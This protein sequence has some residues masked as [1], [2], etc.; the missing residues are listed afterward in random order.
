MVSAHSSGA[1]PSGALKQH[2][3][4]DP[5]DETK[6]ETLFIRWWAES[7]HVPPNPHARMTHLSWGRWLLDK[8]KAEL[9]SK[10]EQA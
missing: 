1:C 9:A 10:E 5:M 4:F 2:H 3:R 7:Y 8:A 6:L